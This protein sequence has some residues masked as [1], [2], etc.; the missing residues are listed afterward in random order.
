M[1]VLGTV[2]ADGTAARGQSTD[3]ASYYL[4]AAV[5]ALLWVY[6]AALPFR[7]LLFVERHAFLLLLVLLSAWSLFHKRWFWRPTPID[8]P[9]LVFIGW[10][11]FTLPFSQ[12]PA[13]SLKEFGKLLQG[14]TIFYAVLYFFQD[15][16]H[17]KYLV[18]LLV[19]TTGLVS[20]YGISQFDPSNQQAMTSFMPAEVWLTT[21]L[22]LLIPLC[23][24]ASYAAERSWMRWAAA[25]IAVSAIICL[26]LVRS[27]AGAVALAVELILMAWLF[28]RWKHAVFAA[29]SA[30]VLMGALW[31]ASLSNVTVPGTNGGTIPMN[32]NVASIVHRFDIWKFMLGEIQKHPVV[33]IG[34]GKDNFLLVYGEEQEEVEPGH[35]RVKNAGAHNILL[36]HA[37]HVGI[38]GAML[39][40]W[41]IIRT[42]KTLF[43]GV[44][45]S[46]GRHAYGVVTGIFVGM[47]G[48]LVRF[49]FDMML[50]GTLAVLFWVLLAIGM[51]HLPE[52][53]QRALASV[54]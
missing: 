10:V 11:A 45:E 17:R 36:Y 6:V 52:T 19:G 40:L 21:Y 43:I 16:A 23:V 38:P 34:Y 12:F 44:K 20:I 51:L 1:N 8:I 24:G 46:S 2:S 49:Q 13:Y 15:G 32:K 4:T 29:A 35:V 48:A 53:K 30:L 7:P 50:V 9:L 42:I 14:I 3:A 54:G 47:I 37:L 41:L 39:F 26:V 22:V 28:R 27:R 18:Y 25:G 31:L 33:G 5:R